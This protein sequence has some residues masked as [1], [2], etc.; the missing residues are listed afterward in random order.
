MF[1]SGCGHE[2][3]AGEARCPKCGWTP[4]S[5]TPPL[6][7]PRSFEFELARYAGKIRV[8]GILWLIWA[9]LFLLMGL[10]ELHLAHAFLS[11]NYGPFAENRHFFPDW[12]LAAVIP[13]ILGTIILRAV[14][15]AIA[16]WGLLERTQW[17]RILAIIAAIISLLKFPFGTALGVATLIILLGYRN[18]AL[19]DSL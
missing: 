9:G 5:L 12:F 19:Y 2:L 15:S 4:P 8:L 17:G 11:G 18:S 16:A 7:P 14:L 6:L 13:F 1:C 3:Q 10:A